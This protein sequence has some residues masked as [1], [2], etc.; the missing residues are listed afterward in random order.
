M[1]IY[2]KILYK[3]HHKAALLGANSPYPVSFS[4]ASR[5]CFLEKNLRSIKWFSSAKGNFSDFPLGLC[6]ALM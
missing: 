4:T 1:L 5:L 3:S 6:T 2:R